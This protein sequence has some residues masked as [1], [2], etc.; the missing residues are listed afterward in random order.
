M[1]RK[2][3]IPAEM[4]DD[5]AVAGLSERARSLLIYLIAHADDEGRLWFHPAEYRERVFTDGPAD[6]DQH[7]GELR[8]AK[9]VILHALGTPR[10]KAL[11][12]CRWFSYQTL[13][14]PSPSSVPPP[15]V[16]RAAY[17]RR[18]LAELLQ[19]YEAHGAHHRY[20]AARVKFREKADLLR[21]RLEGKVKTRSR[22]HLDP[23]RRNGNGSGREM[24]RE[25]EKGVVDGDDHSWEDNPLLEYCLEVTGRPIWSA[26]GCI[27]RAQ[28]LLDSEGREWCLAAAKD[29]VAARRRRNKAP[30][31]HPNYILAALENKMAES[32]MDA[33]VKTLIDDLMAAREGADRVS[34]AIEELLAGKGTST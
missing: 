34:P 13:S 17:V 11:A 30:I 15:P 7:I 16:A 31:T 22:P 8:D 3:M 4:W 25:E 33:D 10:K 32:E 19:F 29:G 5:P 20:P 26:D 23:V 27:R 28:A 12:L 9:L 2:R 6:V 24:E 1:A 18:Y 14:H 21:P